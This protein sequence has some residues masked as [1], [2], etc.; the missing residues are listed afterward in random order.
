MVSSVGYRGLFPRVF[1]GSHRCSLVVVEGVLILLL[2]APYLFS[3]QP[4]VP[5]TMGRQLLTDLPA[6]DFFILKISYPLIVGMTICPL[7]IG[8]THP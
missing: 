1:S 6:S 8:G 2:R 5:R 3:G 4:N 7:S